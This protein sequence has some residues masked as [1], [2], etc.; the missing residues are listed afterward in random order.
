MVY[1]VVL[2]VLK[3]A[4]GGDGGGGG[5]G[6]GDGGGGATLPWRQHT[7]LRHTAHCSAHPT[8]AL[9]SSSL[10]QLLVNP[11]SNTTVYLYYCYR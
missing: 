6:G 7:G 1:R 5:G 8:H 9:P 4:G 10:I 11:H 2:S 3:A